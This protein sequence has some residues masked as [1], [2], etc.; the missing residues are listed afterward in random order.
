[1]IDWWLGFTLNALGL[2]IA[3]HTYLAY[4]ISVA[5]KEPMTFID[6]DG[7]AMC[8]VKNISSIFERRQNT[9]TSETGTL[10]VEIGHSPVVT[11]HVK[12]SMDKVKELNTRGKLGFLIVVAG[13][14]IIFWATALSEYMRAPQDYL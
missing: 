11:Q 8:W 10:I 5:K 4:K 14:N 6:D 13:F 12:T 3:F 7:C 1:L 2:T 9:P